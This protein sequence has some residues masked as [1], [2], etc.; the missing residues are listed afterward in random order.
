MPPEAD[1]DQIAELIA[2]ISADPATRKTVI[3]AIKHVEPKWEVPADIAVDDLREETRAQLDAMRQ[4]NESRRI[5]DE[6]E[7]KRKSIADR[8]GE[9]SV[10]EIET[11]I[12]EKHGIVDYDVA[13]RLYAAEQPPP[14]RERRAR[15]DSRHGATWELP[16]IDLAAYMANPRKAALDEAYKV[17][18]ELRGRR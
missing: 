8:Y 12:M 14:D 9:D 10:K 16:Q 4:E 18:D 2:K 1:R 11:N 15:E 6:L 3:K 7:R 5:R 17:V 13:A